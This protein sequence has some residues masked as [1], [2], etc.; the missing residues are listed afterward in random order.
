MVGIAKILKISL[1]IKVNLLY[2]LILTISS[3]NFPNQAHSQDSNT[4]KVG[5]SIAKPSS[6]F[7][8]NGDAVGIY[9]DIFKEIALKENWNVDYVKNSFD[10]LL[11]QVF[12]GDIDILLN[13]VKTDER[14]QYLLFCKENIASGWSE[15]VVPLNSDISSII[16]FTITRNTTSRKPT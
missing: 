16:D 3:I 7:D 9:I 8:E 1:Q 13:M 2:I 6:Y 14:E 10:V 5:F 12:N 15:I 4:I 11:Q